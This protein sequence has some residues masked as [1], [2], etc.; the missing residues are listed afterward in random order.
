MHLSHTLLTVGRQIMTDD[1]VISLDTIDDLLKTFSAYALD[2][3]A[4][5]LLTTAWAMIHDPENEN[6]YVLSRH[7]LTKTFGELHAVGHASVLS[8][9]V[10]SGILSAIDENGD[11]LLHKRVRFSIDIEVNIERAELTGHLPPAKIYETE[12]EVIDA[13]IALG[14]RMSNE[15]TFNVSGQRRISA[16]MQ[17][18]SQQ[19]RSTRFPFTEHLEQAG[20]SLMDRLAICLLA[21][22]DTAH[23]LM[24]VDELILQLQTFDLIDHDNDEESVSKHLS[25]KGLVKILE[26]QHMR[27]HSI[28]IVLSDDLRTLMRLD[29]PKRGG[30]GGKRYDA[31]GRFTVITPAQGLDD[32]IVDQETTKL[33]RLGVERFRKN[34]T[35]LLAEWGVQVPG[36]TATTQDRLIVLLFGPPGTGKTM[37]AYAMAYELQR[38]VVTIDGSSFL[39]SY[40]GDSEKRLREIFVQLRY[41][42]TKTSTSPVVV[43]NEAD[44]MLHRRIQAEHSADHMRNNLVAIL[45]EEME[46]FEGLLILTVNDVQRMDE[47]FSRRIDMKV[48]ID[49]PDVA[50][51]QRL[52]DLYLPLPYRAAR[53]STVR[54]WHAAT[55]LPADRSD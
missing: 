46:R 45:L 37:A 18:V 5:A 9:M 29:E 44:A 30:I 38:D 39:A 22:A 53:P 27:M 52:W 55:N 12:D 50:L 6:S 8:G 7:L 17:I 33:L 14:K 41:L 47:A 10:D 23:Q 42:R 2:R 19:R 15:P 3:P 40:V 48:R 54:R 20:L 32:V 11:W 21:H 13:Y 34:T 35:R 49:R 4:I 51:R 24:T 16:M 1:A 43:I 28:P 25:Q 26:D 36:Y 31:E